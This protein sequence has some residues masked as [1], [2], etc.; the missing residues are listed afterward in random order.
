[1]G[2]TAGGTVSYGAAPGPFSSIA[3]FCLGGAPLEKGGVIGSSWPITNPF[4][5]FVVSTF[6]LH[7]LEKVP[8]QNLDRGG[9]RT[10]KMRRGVDPCG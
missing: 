5:A 7:S 10:L 3:N 6:P 2:L 4:S 9:V 1:M 8:R